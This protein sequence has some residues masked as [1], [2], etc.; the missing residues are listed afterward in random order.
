M[1]AESVS[2]IAFHPGNFPSLTTLQPFPYMEPMLSAVSHL[3]VVPTAR[4]L[5]YG[6]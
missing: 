6:W 1:D 4:P 2:V 5:S 3:S